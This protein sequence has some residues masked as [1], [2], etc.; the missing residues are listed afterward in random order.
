MAL[1]WQ[2]ISVDHSVTE[3]QME[4]EFLTLLFDTYTFSGGAETVNS[5]LNELPKPNLRPLERINAC[6]VFSTVFQDALVGTGCGFYTNLSLRIARGCYFYAP[7]SFRN[8]KIFELQRGLTMSPYTARLL[9]SRLVETG[10][11]VL[12]QI[13][14]F[15]DWDKHIFEREGIHVPRD[16]LSEKHYWKFEEIFNQGLA[17]F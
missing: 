15:F 13:C 14:L 3:R 12:K 11:P 8:F 6:G 4:Y 1:E 2:L 5:L 16:W 7:R 17:K 9:A 10:N